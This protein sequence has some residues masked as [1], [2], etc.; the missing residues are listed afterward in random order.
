MIHPLFYP[1]KSFSRDDLF[2]H[3]HLHIRSLLVCR[4]DRPTRRGL[5]PSHEPLEGEIGMPTPTPRW[6]HLMQSGK[7]SGMP[8]PLVIWLALSGI[9]SLNLQFK[10]SKFTFYRRWPRWQATDEH[11][12]S[13]EHCT[14]SLLTSHPTLH[15][16]LRQAGSTGTCA[17]ITTLSTTCWISANNISADLHTGNTVNPPPHSIYPFF[18]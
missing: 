12:S 9:K 17:P 2:L 10:Q 16:T 1:F 11:F 8:V 5:W 6:I 7:A 3:L 4:L 18:W 15:S 13:K 14:W